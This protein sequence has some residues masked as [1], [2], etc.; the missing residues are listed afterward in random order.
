MN[1]QEKVKR[2]IGKATGVPT[3]KSGRERKL[4]SMLSGGGCALFL[5]VPFLPVMLL[6]FYLW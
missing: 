3:T 5:L 4:G 1:W 6:A 2:K